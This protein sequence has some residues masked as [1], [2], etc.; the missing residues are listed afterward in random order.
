MSEGVFLDTVG[1]IALLNKDDE[2]HIRSRDLF[3]EIGHSRQKVITTN[4]VLAE[5]GNGL[6]RTPLREDVAWLVERLY[7]DPSAVVVD[8][9]RDRFLEALRLYR[10][11]GDKFWGLVDCAS[12]TVMR[13]MG[14]RRAFT[15]DRHFEQAGFEALLT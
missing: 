11:R 10:Q 5:L 2:Y 12:F 6:A 1:L 14:V 15:A 9:D 8:L 13:E 4:L 3:Q 7:E